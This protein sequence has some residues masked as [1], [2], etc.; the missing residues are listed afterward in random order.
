MKVALIQTDIKWSDPSANCQEAERLMEQTERSD[1]YILPEMCTTGFATEPEGVA[2]IADDE[3]GLTTSFRWMRQMAM[4]HDAAIAGSVATKMPDGTFRN[5][6]LFVTPDYVEHY[7]KRHLFTY[8]GED[9]H[10]KAGERRTIVEW[11][12]VRF[13]LQVCYDLRFPVFS[14][15]K[16]DYDVA[17]YVAN[18][19]ES[20]RR[21]WDALLTARA[22]E[23]QCYVI[24]VNRVGDDLQCH[25]N[26]GSAVIDAYGRTVVAA[27]DKA[28]Q[29]VT[30]TLDMDKLHAFR[31][32]FP[33]LDDGDPFSIE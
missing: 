16:S 1:L 33:V 6:F 8:G 12:G 27:D 32:K 9:R 24:G 26:G 11:R 2:E 21:V 10:Y 17:L 7:D 15:N 30:A 14:R 23:N 19:P 25:Y 28:Q 4:K 5:R 22:I 3:Q 18:W 31:K 29:I 13:L 20:R